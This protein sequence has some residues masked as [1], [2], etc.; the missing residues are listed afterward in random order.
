[1]REN[2]HSKKKHSSKE[3]K[4]KKSKRGREREKID[5]ELKSAR[6]LANKGGGSAEAARWP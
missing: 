5:A 4:Q 1:M 6:E 2:E 3:A